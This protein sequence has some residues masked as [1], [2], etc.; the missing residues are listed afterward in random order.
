MICE[1][2]VDKKKIYCN[3]EKSLNQ[4]MSHKL[5]CEKAKD[6]SANKSDFEIWSFTFY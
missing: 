1:Q 5:Q 3:N 4:F 2:K 6:K